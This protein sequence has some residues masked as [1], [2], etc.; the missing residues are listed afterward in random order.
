MGIRHCSTVD[1]IESEPTE[2]HEEDSVLDENEEI[3]TL[4]K[5]DFDDVDGID[6]D[7]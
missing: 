3:L 5:R 1:V 4:E 6:S 2:D 7:L